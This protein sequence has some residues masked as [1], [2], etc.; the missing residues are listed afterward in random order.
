MVVCWA[1]AS[2]V[3]VENINTARQKF[4]FPDSFSSLVYLFENDDIIRQSVFDTAASATSKVVNGDMWKTV[5]Q[6]QTQNL[7]IQINDTLMNDDVLSC[8]K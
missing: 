8:R 5:G 2:E 4:F 1:I 3:D 7:K 6:T